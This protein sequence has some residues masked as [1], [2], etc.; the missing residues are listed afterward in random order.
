V[1]VAC[2]CSD[3]PYGV[4][5]RAFRPGTSQQKNII[6]IIIIIITIAT[7]IITTLPSSRSVIIIVSLTQIDNI[8]WTSSAFKDI[9]EENKVFYKYV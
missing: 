7:I 6:I 1:P 9:L 3:W 2:A 4:D 8:I 5:R